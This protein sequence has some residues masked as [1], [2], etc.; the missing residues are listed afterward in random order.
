MRYGKV[1]N[2]PMVRF[3]LAPLTRM[4]YH[5]VEC[6]TPNMSSAVVVQQPVPIW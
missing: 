5:R 6:P 4:T 3:R 2:I 1:V